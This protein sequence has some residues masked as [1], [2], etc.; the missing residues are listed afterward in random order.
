MNPMKPTILQSWLVA[1]L[2]CAGLA[3][4]ACKKEAPAGE[5]NASSSAGLPSLPAG[6]VRVLVTDEGFQPARVALKR[7]EKLVF[8]RTSEGTCATEVVFPA[9]KI[10]KRLPLNTDVVVEL[11]Q[12]AS[13]ELDF[14]CGMAMYQSKVVV[15]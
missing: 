3:V 12:T 9:L 8:R 1:H 11:P 15:N 10:E 2:L 14:Q 5:T 13:G 6:S 4:V 7:G